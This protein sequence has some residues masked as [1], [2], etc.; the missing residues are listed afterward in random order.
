MISNTYRFHGNTK[1]K[2][3]KIKL[4]IAYHKLLACLFKSSLRNL[5]LISDNTNHY[6]EKYYIELAV[7]LSH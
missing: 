7:T 2:E 4:I 1:S 6:N 5:E 3:R